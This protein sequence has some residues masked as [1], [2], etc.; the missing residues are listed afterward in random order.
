MA[1][2]DSFDNCLFLTYLFVVCVGAVP[3]ISQAWIN[4]AN[5]HCN[6]EVTPAGIY[7]K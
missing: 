1:K 2:A 6:P 7:C 5:E 3:V 4:A